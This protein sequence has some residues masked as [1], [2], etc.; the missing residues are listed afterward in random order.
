MF[1][2]L[3]IFNGECAALKTLDYVID[4]TIHWLWKNEC[5]F[6]SVFRMCSPGVCNYFEVLVYIVKLLSHPQLSL[7]KLYWDDK[8][9]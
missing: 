4:W 8:L 3:I 6:S 2:S 9:D 7:S 5:K 1:W